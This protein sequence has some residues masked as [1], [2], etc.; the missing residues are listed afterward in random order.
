MY[1]ENTMLKWIIL[2]A[3]IISGTIL[4]FFLQQ[5]KVSSPT[6]ASP[7]VNAV[8]ITHAFKDGVHRYDGKLR[9]PHS[10][11]GVTADSNTRDPGTVVLILRTTDNLSEAGLCL[12]IPTVYPFEVVVDA[13][14]DAKT[15]LLVNGVDTTTSLVETAWTDPRGTILNLENQPR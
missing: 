13:R 6:S 10:C 4:F 3:V 8:T 12:K 5:L 14:Q 2:A 9:L 15:V 11:Y 1:D 7:A